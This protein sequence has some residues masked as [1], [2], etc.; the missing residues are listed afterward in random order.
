M[1]IFYMVLSWRMETLFRTNYLK[2]TGHERTREIIR[3]SE[4]IFMLSGV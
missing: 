4:E 2:E 3:F 1:W